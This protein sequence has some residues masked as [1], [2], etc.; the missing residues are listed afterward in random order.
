M[1]AVG[2]DRT[3]NGYGLNASRLAAFWATGC[4]F[5]CSAFDPFPLALG[6]LDAEATG[7]KTEQ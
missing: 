7:P 2:I 5:C 1:V 6:A 4:G 3:F